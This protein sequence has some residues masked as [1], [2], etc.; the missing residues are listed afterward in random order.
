[1]FLDSG[2]CEMP[3]EDGR[4][5]TWVS[6]EQSGIAVDA[7]SSSVQNVQCS[8]SFFGVASAFGNEIPIYYLKKHSF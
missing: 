1:M 2:L 4:R 7:S 5:K 3:K 6:Y 8:G